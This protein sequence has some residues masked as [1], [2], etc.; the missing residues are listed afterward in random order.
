M[1][2]N[3]VRRKLELL[4]KAN[5]EKFARLSELAKELRCSKTEL[6]LEIEKNPGLYVTSEPWKLGLKSNPGLLIID[7]FASPADNYTQPEFLERLREENRNTVHIS[8]LSDYVLR[9]RYI[10]EDK[11]RRDRNGF[12]EPDD[13]DHRKNFHLWR[14]T[15]EKIARIEAAGHCRKD[16]YFGGCDGLSKYDFDHC[17]TGEDLLALVN[18]GWTLTGEV[19]DELKSG[20]KEPTP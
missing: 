11:P 15:A 13:K 18:E 12:P 6:M 7:V 5:C 4:K 19:P 20:S 3:V 2:A 16:R 10:L 9:G 8:A 1:D 14:N 17:V